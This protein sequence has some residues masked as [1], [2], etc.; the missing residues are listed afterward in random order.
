MKKILLSIISIIMLFGGVMLS[1]CGGGD[2][3]SSIVLESD[4]FVN[5]DKD[6]IEIDITEEESRTVEIKATIENMEQGI[7]SVKNPTEGGVVFAETRYNASLNTN[8]ITITTLGEGTADII[9]GA[10]GTGRK[11]EDKKIRV[12]VYSDITGIVQ[13]VDAPTGKKTQYIVMDQNIT[14]ES[15]NYLDI[16]AK[17]SCNR[18]DIVWSVIEDYGNALT[19]RNG[20][21][22]RLD[23]Y[24]FKE[25]QRE[26]GED[27]SQITI[28]AQSKYRPDIVTEV[29]LDILT[30]IADEDATV[31]GA[32]DIGG[33]RFELVDVDGNIITQELVRT[34]S[35]DEHSTLYYFVD[36]KTENNIT[37]VS[38]TDDVLFKNFDIPVGTLDITNELYSYDTATKTHS[39]VFKVVNENSTSPANYEFNFSFAYDNYDYVFTTQDVKIA[40]VDIVTKIEVTNEKQEVMHDGIVVDIYNSYANGKGQLFNVDLTPTTAKDTSYYLKLKVSKDV[41]NAPAFNLTDY[42]EICTEAGGVIG[43]SLDLSIVDDDYAY[44][45]STDAGDL[46]TFLNGTG[47]YVKSKQPS[48]AFSLCFYSN[49]KVE[50]HTVTNMNFVFA[51][52]EDFA[53]TAAKFEE[54]IE[55]SVVRTKTFDFSSTR[56]A[57]VDV[58]SLELIYP[59]SEN[60][61]VSALRK[62]GTNLS[63]D[64]TTLKTDV[65]ETFDIQLAHKNG[66]KAT[67]K[68]NVEL[69][70]A[71]TS[72]SVS[73]L[74]ANSD[75]IAQYQYTNQNFGGGVDH[76]LAQLIINFGTGVEL[77][78]SHDAG[79]DV[80]I[81]IKYF[82]NGVNGIAEFAGLSLEDEISAFFASYDPAKTT[83]GYMEY[84]PS[85]K[86]LNFMTSK[87]TDYRGYVVV[88][89]NGY[90]ID[91]NPTKLYRIIDVESYVP[92]SMLSTK[93]T[94]IETIA[95]DSLSALDAEELS[96][97]NV[98]V[99]FRN[100]P[101]TQIPIT[102]YNNVYFNDTV[103]GIRPN[104]TIYSSSASREG[105]NGNYEFRASNRTLYYKGLPI[106]ALNDFTVTAKNMNFNIY[107]YSTSEFT[108]FVDTLVVE[109]NS[110]FSTFRLSIDIVISNSQRVTSLIWENATDDG[111]MYLLLS[112]DGKIGPNNKHT[113]I[114]TVSEAYN[115]SL[116]YKYNALSGQ[117]DVISFADNGKYKDVLVNPTAR[118]GGNGYIYVL[119]ADSVKTND[120]INFNYYDENGDIATDYVSISSLNF[121]KDEISW[122][123]Y[124]MESAF[125]IDAKGEVV[126][127]NKILV[128]IHLI[129]ADGLS[130]DTAFRIY[131]ADE[132]ASMSYVNHYVLMNDVKLTLTAPLFDK[133]NPT[134]PDLLFVGSL[135]GYEDDVT[136]TLENSTSLFYQIGEAG[137]VYNITF[138][139][140]VD[141][142][143]TGYN[144]A[145]G[146]AF[147]AYINNGLVDNVTIDVWYDGTKYVPSEVKG[148]TFAGAIA[149]ENKGTIKNSSVL[150]VSIVGQTVGGIAG[151]HTG[152][153]ENCRVELYK[154]ATDVAGTTINNQFTASSFA[155]GIVGS[156]ASVSAKIASTYIYDYTLDGTSLTSNI[157]APNKG[158]FVGSK[159][160][161]S[162]TDKVKIENSFAVVNIK[163]AASTDFVELKDA[164]I[165]YF[166]DDGGIKYHSDTTITN[167]SNWIQEGE[168]N[169]NPKANGFGDEKFAHLKFH[170]LEFVDISALEFVEDNS[171][172]KVNEKTAIIFLYEVDTHTELTVVEKLA[173]SRKNTYSLKTLFGLEERLAEGLVVSSSDENIVEANMNDIEVKKTGKITLNVLSKQDFS[174]S[175]PYNIEVIRIIKDFKANYNGFETTGIEVQ[176][177][178]SAQIDFTTLTSTYLNTSTNFSLVL[179]KFAVVTD[180]EEIT[181]G[182]DTYAVYAVENAVGMVNVYAGAKTAIGSFVV[183]S[184]VSLST[185]DTAEKREALKAYTL[186]ELTITP[187]EG[188]NEIGVDYSSITIYPSLSTQFEVVLDTDS[189][190]DGLIITGEFENAKLNVYRVNPDKSLTIIPTKQMV[191]APSESGEFVLAF[192]ALGKRLTVKITASAYNITTNEI[193]YS[194]TVKIHDEYKS[195]ISASE[196]YKLIFNSKN[197]KDLA[198][199]KTLNVVLESQKIDNIDVTNYKISQVTNK[200]GVYNYTKTNTSVSLLAPGQSSIFEVTVD[201]KYS[202]YEYLTVRYEPQASAALTFS[203]LNKVAT[204]YTSNHNST[205]T[206][207]AYGVKV[208]P[209][210]KTSVYAFKLYVSTSV[211]SDC[212]IPVTVSFYGYNEDG[213]PKLLESRVV[214]IYV[215]CMKQPSVLVNG[216]EFTKVSKGSNAK[217]EV[218]VNTDQDLESLTLEGNG[219]ENI[220]LSHQNTVDNQDGTKTYV[221]ALNAS[222]LARVD[223][224]MVTNPSGVG[225]FEIKGTI[226]R[227]LDGVRETKSMTAMVALVEFDVSS[228]EIDGAE[229]DEDFGMD[230]FTAY[231]NV[232]KNFEFTYNFIP[233]SYGM[234]LTAEETAVMAT[235]NARKADFSRDGYYTDG[236]SYYINYE[237]DEEERT[238][239]PIA[240]KDQLYVVS[241]TGK[242]QKLNWTE[243]SGTPGDYTYTHYDG[244]YAKFKITYYGATKQF[245]IMGNSTTAGT[246]LFR[247]KNIIYLATAGNNVY[248]ESNYDFGIRVKSYTSEDSPEA[249]NTAQ[250]FLDIVK[251]G[252]AKPYILMNDIVLENYNPFDTTLIASLDGNGH[253]IHINSFDKSKQTGTFNAALFTTVTA[254]TILKNVRVNWYN[255]GQITVDT[256]IETG[257]G[258]VRV[259]GLAITNNGIIYNCEAVAYYSD[260]H[261]TPIVGGEQG[262]VVSYTRGQTPYEI[263]GNSSVSSIIAGLVIENAG[264]ITNSR[265]GGETLRLLDADMD[266]YVGRAYYKDIALETFTISGQ[267]EVNGFVSNNSKNI[268]ASKATNVQITNNSAYNKMET[269]GFVNTNSGSIST[270]YVAGKDDKTSTFTYLTTTIDSDGVIAGFVVTNSTG[271]SITNC[272]SN[273]KIANTSTFGSGFVYKNEGKISY[274]FSASQVERASFTQMGFT[275]LDEKGNILSDKGEITFS[276]Y[277][278]M[279][280]SIGST[281][282]HQIDTGAQLLDLGASNSILQYYGLSFASG[283]GEK[284]MLANGDGIW[285]MRD[286]GKVSLIAADTIAYSVRYI[287]GQAADNSFLYVYC[288][289]IDNDVESYTFG[290]RFTTQLGSQYNPII[291][292]SAKD[293]DEAMGNSKSTNI[294]SYYNAKEIFG[295]YRFVNNISLDDLGTNAEGNVSVSSTSRALTLKRDREGRVLGIG[296]I[297][298]NGFKI[299]NISIATN[300]KSVLGGAHTFGLFASI[301]N[302]AKVLNLNLGILNVTAKDTYIVGGLAGLVYHSSVINVTVDQ[303]YTIN[304]SEDSEASEDGILGQNVAGGVV[305][306]VFGYSTI[307]SVTINNAI[308][309]V[310]Y[311][312]SSRNPEDK[313]FDDGLLDTTNDKFYLGGGLNLLANRTN[314]LTNSNILS[315]FSNYSIAGGVAGY[316]DVFNEEQRVQTAYVHQTI[317]ERVYRIINILA[318]KTVNVRGEVVGGLFGYTSPTSNAENV[319]LRL[320]VDLENGTLISKILSYNSYAGGIVGI[321]NGYIYRA[322][323]EHD[324]AT[325]KIIE[326][327]YKNYYQG[328]EEEPQRGI[329]DLFYT[330]YTG[331]IA[332][333]YKTQ[334]IGGIAGVMING[335]IENSYSKINVIAKPQS[336]TVAGGIV[337]RINEKG[338]IFSFVIDAKEG[339]GPWTTSTSVFMKEVYASG[340][341]RGGYYRVLRADSTYQY[342]GY[343]GGIVGILDRNAVLGVQAVNAVNAFSYDDVVTTAANEGDPK[344]GALSSVGVYALVSGEGS[345][346]GTIKVIMPPIYEGDGKATSM[347]EKSVGY[348]GSITNLEGEKIFID[349]YPGV[350]RVSYEPKQGAQA[351]FEMISVS[352]FTSI[353]DG[354]N[355]VLSGFL[356]S[357]RHWNPTKWKHT[358]EFIYPQIKYT[359]VKTQVYLDRDNIAEVVAQMQHNTELVVLVRGLDPETGT[360]G[361]VD[362]SGKTIVG[363]GGKLIGPAGWLSEEELSNGIIA[364][365]SKNGPFVGIN[366]SGVL[367]TNSGAFTC[368][369]LDIVYGVRNTDPDKNANTPEGERKSALEGK[370][371]YAPTAGSAFISGFAE[372]VDLNNLKF[373]IINHT[374]K[375]TPSNG[376]AGFIASAIKNCNLEN[377]EIVVELPDSVAIPHETDGAV[378]YVENSLSTAQLNVGVFAGNLTIGGTYAP[379]GNKVSIQTADFKDIMLKVKNSNANAKIMNIGGLI[380]LIDGDPAITIDDVQPAEILNFSTDNLIEMINNIT[381]PEADKNQ[382]EAFIG[383]Q[384]G[385]IK[386]VRTLSAE[387]STGTAK[388][389]A[390]YLKGQFGNVYY[391][392]I[393]G[394][395][396]DLTTFTLNGAGTIGAK[397]SSSSLINSSTI[398]NALYAGGVFG[399]ARCDFAFEGAEAVS[400]LGN[401]FGFGN[402]YNGT[403]DPANYY[404]IESGSIGGIIG[405]AESQIAIS[406]IDAEIKVGSAG[407]DVDATGTIS[408]DVCFNKSTNGLINIGGII[409]QNTNRLVVNNTDLRGFVSVD[410]KGF[411]GGGVGLVSAEAYFGTK[412]ASG[413]ARD[414]D[415]GSV[416][417]WVDIITNGNIG[418]FIGRVD[419]EKKVSMQDTMY[420]GTI[421]IFT[422]TGQTNKNITIG[423]VIGFVEKGAWSSQNDI[424][425]TNAVFGGTI[426]LLGNSDETYYEGV[427]SSKNILHSDLVVT[428]GGIVGQFE[429]AATGAN[430]IGNLTSCYTYGDVIVSYAKDFTK[431]A[432]YA[433]GG[434]IGRGCNTKITNSVSIMTNNNDKVATTS[435]VG[436]IVG[437]NNAA[438]A[439]NYSGNKYNSSMSLGYDDNATDIGYFKNYTTSRTGRT[440]SNT[441]QNAIALIE[442]A[443]KQDS[444]YGNSFNATVEFEVNGKIV[445]PKGSK[446]NPYDYLMPDG[447]VAKT[448]IVY[449]AQ[450]GDIAEVLEGNLRLDDKITCDGDYKDEAGNP[451]SF[452]IGYVGDGFSTKYS[453]EYALGER[454][455]ASYSLFHTLRQNDFVAGAVVTIDAEYDLNQTEDTNAGAI[456]GKQTGGVIFASSALGTLSVGANFDDS[457]GDINLGGIVGL[458]ESGII[459]ETYSAVDLVYRAG[460]GGGNVSGFAN[461]EAKTTVGEHVGDVRVENCFSTGKVETYCSAN[462]YAFATADKATGNSVYIKNCYTVSLIDKHNHISEADPTGDVANFKK[463][464]S[465]TIEDC[466]FSQDATTTDEGEGTNKKAY[467]LGKDEA[468]GGIT[469]WINPT[470]ETNYGYPVRDFKYLQPSTKAADNHILVPN[471]E[472]LKQ[473][474][475]SGK[476]R[477]LNNID[478][479]KTA[480][481]SAQNKEKGLLDVTFAGTFDGNG[482]TIYNLKY[483]GLFTAIS[484]A[485]INSL[486]LTDVLV[487][488]SSAVDIGA[489]AGTVNGTTTIEDVSVSGFVTLTSPTKTAGG[490]VGWVAGGELT[491][492]NCNNFARVVSTDTAA[493]SNVA[494]IVGGTDPAKLNIENCTNYGT[495]ESKH[496]GYAGGIVGSAIGTNTHTFLKC[497]NTNSIICGYRD[498]APNTL[499]YAGGIAGRLKS[500]TIKECYNTA[501]IK[502]G[503]KANTNVAYA[504]GILGYYDNPITNSVVTDCL[505]EGNVEAL[506]S[507]EGVATTY[508][509]SGSEATSAVTFK[510]NKD[511]KFT[512]Y[513]D[514]F[515]NFSSFGTYDFIASGSDGTT[516]TTSVNYGQ[517]FRNGLFG[518]YDMTYTGFDF[519]RQGDD[520]KNTSF[521]FEK[522]SSYAGNYIWSKIGAASEITGVYMQ[523]IDDLGGPIQFFLTIPRKLYYFSEHHSSIVTGHAIATRKQELFG[524][525]LFNATDTYYEKAHKRETFGE[526]GATGAKWKDVD[527][528]KQLEFMVPKTQSEYNAEEKIS[529]TVMIG[530]QYYAIPEN[531]GGLIGALENNMKTHST[532]FSGTI[533]GKSLTELNSAGYTFS[534]NITGDATYGGDDIDSIYATTSYS[535]GSLTITFN[536]AAART[537]G[538]LSVG[539]TI[540]A[541][542][543]RESIVSSTLQASSVAFKNN[544][545]KIFLDN[546]NFGTLKYD[547]NGDGDTTD[548]SVTYNGKTYNETNLT[549]A[550]YFPLKL[551][552]GTSYKVTVNLIATYDML[553]DYSENTLTYYQTATN[554]GGVTTPG[555]E[556]TGDNVNLF[557]DK[558]I[559]FDVNQNDTLEATRI[560]MDTLNTF[561]KETSITVTET[562]SGSYTQT[563]SNGTA[564]FTS[565]TISGITPTK[566]ENLTNSIPNIVERFNYKG[567]TLD[568]AITTTSISVD[569][570]SYGYT[571]GITPYYTRTNIVDHVA[572]VGTYA[573]TKTYNALNTSISFNGTTYS[574]ACD[575]SGNLSFNGGASSGTMTIS[576]ATYTYTLTLEGDNVVCKIVDEGGATRLNQT[577]TRTFYYQTTQSIGGESKT[578][579][580]QSGTLYIGGTAATTFAVAGESHRVSFNTGISSFVVEK[581]GKKFV[582]TFDS[583]TTLSTYTTITNGSYQDTAQV[584]DVKPGDTIDTNVQTHLGI[585]AHQVYGKAT[586]VYTLSRDNITL[587]AGSIVANLTFSSVNL[588]TETGLGVDWISSSPFKRTNSGA[589][590][591]DTYYYSFTP[592]V[593]GLTQSSLNTAS[594]TFSATVSFSYILG[595]AVVKVNTS[596]WAKQQTQTATNTLVVTATYKVESHTL[597]T[598]TSV[599][600]GIYKVAAANVGSIS[601]S[602]SY[603]INLGDNQVTA[604]L[605]GVAADGTSKTVEFKDSGDS[606]IDGYNIFDSYRKASDKS[607]YVTNNNKTAICANSGLDYAVNQNAADL[608]TFKMGVIGYEGKQY[609]NSKTLLVNG[610]HD[611]TVNVAGTNRTFTATVDGNNITSVVQY[612]TGATLTLATATTTYIYEDTIGGADYLVQYRVI[613]QAGTKKLYVGVARTDAYSTSELKITSTALKTNVP[614]TGSYSGSFNYLNGGATETLYWRYDYVNGAFGF[615]DTAGGEVS[616]TI[617]EVRE[618]DDSDHR[619]YYYLEEVKNGDNITINLKKLSVFLSGGD[620]V[621]LSDTGINYMSNTETE[622]WKGTDGKLYFTGQFDN[623]S[624]VTENYAYVVELN[625]LS[626]QIDVE[627]KVSLET[628][629]N[630]TLDATLN[631]YVD[632]SSISVTENNGNS[633]MI[634]NTDYT[635][636]GTT[637]TFN[638]VMKDTSFTVKYAYLKY[639]QARTFSQNVSFGA[640]G[641]SIAGIIL[642]KDFD[643]KNREVSM[644]SKISGKGHFITYNARNNGYFNSVGNWLKDINVGGSI[645]LNVSTGKA[646]ILSKESSAVTLKRVNTYGSIATKQAQTDTSVKL[647]GVFGIGDSLN[648][649]NVSSYVNFASYDDNNE[650]ETT[651]RFGGIAAEGKCVEGGVNNVQFFGTHFGYDGQDAVGAGEQG[652]PGQSVLSLGIKDNSDHLVSDVSNGIVEPGIGGNTKTTTNGSNGKNSSGKTQ[653]VGVGTAGGTETTD[654]KAIGGQIDENDSGDD[655]KGRGTGTNAVSAKNGLTGAN[656]IVAA[657][658]SASTSTTGELKYDGWDKADTVHEFSSG[659]YYCNGSNTA[660]SYKYK[661]TYNSDG[662][663]LTSHMDITNQSGG[664]DTCVVHFNAG[665]GGVFNSAKASASANAVITTDDYY[666]QLKV[667]ASAHYKLWSWSNGSHTKYKITVSD[668]WWLVTDCA[669]GVEGIKYNVAG[670]SKTGSIPTD[671][672]IAEIAKAS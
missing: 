42:V 475:A 82:I 552:D 395:V 199:T 366:L 26:I 534:V 181:D 48:E 40:L 151:Q 256:A 117:N 630:E 243:V 89:F 49:A 281:L 558:Y 261:N 541:Q 321:G 74:K 240:L 583:S 257:F 585:S 546:V 157:V 140:T 455:N 409:G 596:N 2:V 428:V 69:F 94:L 543:G 566:T 548:T 119:P 590:N 78:F 287:A 359:S 638:P 463:V 350:L 404:A 357:S 234:N 468:G 406:S 487:E 354:Y 466:Y 370:I 304:A 531:E 38:L 176:E 621:S 438:S 196:R 18:K 308:T 561:D 72:A 111:T 106:Y 647:G 387:A 193:T 61:K 265:V 499:Y 249:I 573:G 517:I 215:T 274:C 93:S 233:E 188:S 92:V 607:F 67:T 190:T 494:G 35:A 197:D 447:M 442:T 430:A 279:N 47:I 496:Y 451:Y 503:H 448:P 206:N 23:S 410:T 513:A 393:I 575:A 299:E 183:N 453:L 102:Y 100:D 34:N 236:T 280:F 64:V 113:I 98:D 99:K 207:I 381:I 384:I 431:F 650:G 202:Y 264:N 62:T 125:F 105:V 122:Y 76:S 594:G 116:V 421:H 488:N 211:S 540:V 160:Y 363:F 137:K 603:R 452:A 595:D 277:Y 611:V 216:S 434:I 311:Y 339:E 664:L 95:S 103:G 191:V 297:D 316:I 218:T 130:E 278:D 227:V 484:G 300:E 645:F 192:G 469:G 571:L 425:I 259:A 651:S 599:D 345:S 433:F 21:L 288:D 532:T 529:K 132:V 554:V 635:V 124:L 273:I 545:T 32:Y 523:Q 118:V 662:N 588:A 401:Y 369:T 418:G 461:I 258:G 195:S 498:T 373:H 168:E 223:Y 39:Y 120:L 66:F 305:G 275:G 658:L 59:Q 253:T 310:S 537:S 505:N 307:K 8:T 57:S 348:F 597:T 171:F 493:G 332:Y 161:A 661:T 45:N 289:M 550:Q 480:S 522:T 555:Y 652:Q 245:V 629:K 620:E 326:E 476:Y 312:D 391:G 269:A 402:T 225:Q 254:N 41:A 587:T 351:C 394:V 252:E 329:L 81:E 500:A 352:N 605:T 30:G 450:G 570:A 107:A 347:A 204:G 544:T 392:G 614:K 5:D 606:I 85:L 439:A 12:F 368:S 325:Q 250:Q 639:E 440:A 405:K 341:V 285:Y 358:E 164:Y 508:T 518:S 68:F 58:S 632:T 515:A 471:A 633:T 396:Q 71:I 457:T 226:A 389:N 398:K 198:L 141:T 194:I 569:S 229:F 156:V 201:P 237:Y 208:V 557:K 417:S 671:R 622:G 436:P 331:S 668:W 412:P 17:A 519:L 90:D 378:I 382:Y 142:S 343:G 413:F 367:F 16:S 419:K 238:F 660:T 593:T 267:G 73:L 376:N 416:K 465:V 356:V 14:L 268:A 185:L 649:Q 328:G 643:M 219:I 666:L 612:S 624:I 634:R 388:N 184:Y 293:F 138:N 383:G 276:Y 623:S 346:R 542:R 320:S 565:A 521:G 365:H 610:S 149:Q 150:G 360:Y 334:V 568:S 136:I 399:V 619:S 560:M 625:N 576:G 19:I 478:L 7:V 403:D 564:S 670:T 145:T 242:E 231:E 432:D 166:K 43:F 524:E 6:Y 222:L 592:T 36:I 282:E 295:S 306:V 224:N 296:Q 317:G 213:S 255:G 407:K 13:K 364:R 429:Y 77:E 397:I 266:N 83:T 46:R 411:I 562:T 502:S 88:E 56:L 423:G 318:D 271:A 52:E 319:K 482:K 131:T 586:P 631:N 60:Y 567:E 79:D 29:T 473:A 220:T 456:A 323:L 441:T 154:F 454:K 115:T 162:L 559:S 214:D 589:G 446:I 172:I 530:A 672:Y 294:S 408:K 51:P 239:S 260:A 25:Y 551:K 374:F 547:I 177:G 337:G 22:L 654:D 659:D 114:T 298:G 510:Y 135:R 459:N 420:S 667:S 27:V 291:I 355:S 628:L 512:V 178:R 97:K 159:A 173:L 665:A 627:T 148:L 303:N 165:S 169:F 578:F 443:L 209:T 313:Y 579:K 232:R 20:N 336:A 535:S 70:R 648:L 372:N 437:I 449:V 324:D 284:A 309:K 110:F 53:I 187:F 108:E 626:L 414:V 486:N 112:A 657:K 458:V 538:I 290:Q 553:Y 353:I 11:I 584:K 200:N 470:I 572:N 349:L 615:T 91:H 292:S 314:L 80:V 549:S 380:G 390:V 179:D 126:P 604:K 497:G 283:T 474:T 1:A 263:D 301:K 485:T 636:S 385:Q 520:D 302:N 230:V 504:G 163:D 501:T 481:Y 617:F 600:T 31:S 244:N 235:L 491:I 581:V 644:A 241:S 637:I 155:G 601:V 101:N 158:A 477:L 495:I 467:E 362:L 322:T 613:T 205:V 489:V 582:Y 146:G 144:R 28:Q 514:A 490:L 479:S 464:G 669:V 492:K 3:V 121:K 424:Q 186:K 386:G 591:A 174:I 54:K 9:I 96:S 143:A 248:W 618:S 445:N 574:V 563:A 642:E 128:R 10:E 338:T 371:E 87:R 598:G 422:K 536:F 189:A 506:G 656:G 44:Y 460:N 653:A 228:V 129:V 580:Y 608:T 330:T 525:G 123:D 577:L 342:F 203:A 400:K 507:I 483:V 37:W 526:S 663:D 646:G 217:V 361:D 472:V 134:D 539:Y 262:L 641:I 50:V 511:N 63:F 315:M 640:G 335:E 516:S 609:Y 104:F 127:F 270:S 153:I 24:L 86:T 33:T 528:V 462:A 616:S 509:A 175:E 210:V 15:E 251:Q 65:N 426:L 170:Q 246:V 556:I 379:T 84:I 327:G 427:D 55:T 247:L 435:N 221:Y 182:H 139:G 109:Y 152:T 527:S 180:N 147:V 286:D 272:L 4:A 377:L 212:I 133:I 415:T 333:D 602:K 444:V 344:T 533:G 340:D 375:I 167:A 75:N 655:Y